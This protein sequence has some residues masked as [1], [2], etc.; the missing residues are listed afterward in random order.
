MLPRPDIHSLLN[1]ESIRCELRR[2]IR[3]IESI[4]DSSATADSGKQTDPANPGQET[5]TSPVDEARRSLDRLRQEIDDFAP[6]ARPPQAGNSSIREEWIRLVEH[7]CAEVEQLQSDHTD[8]FQAAAAIES[9]A[10]DADPETDASRERSS[11]RC[12]PSASRS[13][14]SRCD[15]PVSCC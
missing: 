1:F 11:S 4:L 15:E 13:S 5:R 9:D 3:K 8:L 14:Q 6:V 10:T 2:Y 12:R 7:V